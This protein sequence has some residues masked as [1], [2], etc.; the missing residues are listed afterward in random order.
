MDSISPDARLLLVVS[1]KEAR[2]SDRTDFEVD[3]R[4][5]VVIRTELTKDK[6]STAQRRSEL[7]AR[8][9]KVGR[10]EI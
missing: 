3:E 1:P 5:Y 6:R 2:Q 10:T 4:C 7:L 9:P 8:T